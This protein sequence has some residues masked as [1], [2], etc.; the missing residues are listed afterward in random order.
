MNLPNGFEFVRASGW[1]ELH[2]VRCT[3]CDMQTSLCYDTCRDQD[4]IAIRQ[5]VYSHECE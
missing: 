2:H 5:F 4:R 3:S 1:W